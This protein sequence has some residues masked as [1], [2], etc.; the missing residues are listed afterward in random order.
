MLS[1]FPQGLMKSRRGRESSRCMKHKCIY[2]D[3]VRLGQEEKEGGVFPFSPLGEAYF[4]VV[5]TL[6]TLCT[7]QKCFHISI[8]YILS[9][10]LLAQI[11]SLIIITFMA[12][13]EDHI[14]GSA[15]LFV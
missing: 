14:L 13:F 8:H 9:M 2:G 3:L 1:V 11:L 5:L 15:L 4:A 10:D 6:C 12:T 7:Q